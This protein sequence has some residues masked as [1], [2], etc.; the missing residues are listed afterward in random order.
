[1]QNGFVI[2][3]IDYIVNIVPRPLHGISVDRIITIYI[4]YVHE[5]RGLYTLIRTY[6]III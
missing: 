2:Y 6:I 3:F 5:I 4:L 1:M